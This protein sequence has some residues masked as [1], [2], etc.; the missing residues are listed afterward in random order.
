[1]DVSY[2][3]QLSDELIHLNHAAVAPWPM[4]TVEAVTRF[5]EENLTCGS[6][7]YAEWLK[8]E[9]RLRTQIASLIHAPSA[10]DIALVKNTSEALSFVAAGIDWQTGD[11]IVTSDQEFPSNRIVWEAL[12]AKGV[13]L[14]QATL[15]AA[16][17]PEDALFA[18]VDGNTRLIAISSVQYGTGLHMDLQRIGNFCRQ[19]N[20]LFCVDAIQSVGAI[21]FDVNA[22]DADFAAADGH[23]W[24]CGPEGLGFFYTR[25]DIRDELKLSQF[26]WHMVEEIGNFDRTDWLPAS[27][28]RRFECGSPNMLSIHALH[29]SLSV[30]DDVGMRQIEDLVLQNSRYLMQTLKSL[31]GVELL[32]PEQEGRYAGIVTFKVRGFDSQQIYEAL[33]SQRVFCACRAGGVRLSPHFYTPR[34][35]LQEA[36]SRV[37]DIVNN[38]N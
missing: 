37:S 34:V 7:H 31:S 3:F 29:A 11:N 16:D 21:K 35:K 15:A 4:R 17:S 10:D 20:I 18:L 6:W 32:T 23:K 36:L 12:A 30:I 13:S 8:I 2:E 38:N 27:S 33:Q 19:H 1:M 9:E 28:A 25:K 26:G 24:M 14:R 22:I 5:A